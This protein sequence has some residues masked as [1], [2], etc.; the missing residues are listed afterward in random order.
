[1]RKRDEKAKLSL[2]LTLNQKSINV[3]TTD[4]NVRILANIS[5][6]R[7]ALYLETPIYLYKNDF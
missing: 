2:P 4:I 6:L 3:K 7:L 5:L 1:L